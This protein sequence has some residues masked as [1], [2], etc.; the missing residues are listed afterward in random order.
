MEQ[1]ELK[2][3]YDKKIKPKVILGT[4]NA[5]IALFL[6][7]FFPVVGIYKCSQGKFKEK[8][9]LN[10]APYPLNELPTGYSGS[11][12]S[13]YR[14]NE[15]NDFNSQNDSSA[16]GSWNSPSTNSKSNSSIPDGAKSVN[17]NAN[18]IW[19][20]MFNRYAV[21]INVKN[22]NDLHRIYFKI[23][24]FPLNHR[25]P[26]YAEVAYEV[27][28]KDKDYLFTFYADNYWHQSGYDDG[29]WHQWNY[30]EDFEIE[31][32]KPGTYYLIAGVPPGRYHDTI[33][34]IMQRYSNGQVSA[35]IWSGIK[36]VSVF[37]IVF[38]MIFF[39]ITSVILL[40]FRK[41]QM[42]KYNLTAGKFDFE[43]KN[44]IVKLPDTI[45]DGLFEVI[46]FIQTEGSY[47]SKIELI[48]SKDNQSSF[49]EVER[50]I[51]DGK[52]TYY[53]Y[54][55][56]KFPEQNQSFANFTSANSLLYEG[57]TYRLYNKLSKKKVKTTY[58]NGLTQESV[59]NIY[60]FSS[61]INY[62]ENW[63]CL[64]YDT[65]KGINEY[66]V[67][68]GIKINDMNIWEVNKT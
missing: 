34:S 10:V 2:K 32:P 3:I 13:G 45:S 9:I 11:G 67:S 63:L 28:N 7:F 37:P 43:N 49:L 66:E 26:N 59:K 18:R 16:S 15:S 21:K 51:D 50:E 64:E 33:Y 40:I 60:N 30:T 8:V 46:G 24:G 31:F 41:G 38:S 25:N 20:S 35:I 56:N 6:V 62:I 36:S 14:A 1:E 42:N 57:H 27:Y 68:Q 48:V 44:Y 52:T 29:Y 54:L 61:N 65:S 47:Y 4:I 55:Y 22:V 23:G 12:T 39:G 53:Y 19:T 17:T 5:L 58:N